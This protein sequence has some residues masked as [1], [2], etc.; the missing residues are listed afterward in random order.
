MGLQYKI[1]FVN[2]WLNLAVFSL[3]LLL[4]SSCKHPNPAVHSETAIKTDLQ[5][6][7]QL[8]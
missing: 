8:S 3:A 1:Y 6:S 5:Y 2:M 4:L 7:Q